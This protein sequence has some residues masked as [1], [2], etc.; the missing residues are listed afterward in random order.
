MTDKVNGYGKGTIAVQGTYQPEQGGTRVLPLYQSTTYAYETAEDTAALFNLQAAGHLYSRISNPTVASFEEK[1]ALLEGGVGAVATASGMAAI[2]NSIVNI[3]QAGDTILSSN[4][5]YGGTTNLFIANLP[6]FGIKTI[7]FD[8][9]A[10][11]EEISALADETTKLVFAET[12]SNPS[13]EVLDFEKISKVAKTLDV[14]LIIDSSLTG[15]ALINPL[16]LGAD[17]VVHSTSKYIDGHASAV[18]GIVVDGGKFNWDNGKYPELVEP[19]ESYHGVRYVADFG[20]GA[21]TTKL[22]V[23][24]VRD[25]GNIQNPFNAYLTNLGSETLDLRCQKHSSNALA[26]AEWLSQQEVVTFVK[27]PGLKTDSQY[28]LGQKYLPK[29][30]SGMVSFGVK[31]GAEAAK[32]F[33]NQLDL[34]KLVTHCAD[35]RS[36]VIHPASTTHRQLSAEQQAASGVTADLIRLSVGIEE[37]EDIIGDIAQSL[38]KLS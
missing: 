6:K 24:I 1:I 22:R 27:Y 35:I 36:S 32:S 25:L 4:Q 26:V 5:I 30:A 15:P 31:G 17:I 9:N 3:A 8:Q 10:S 29:G 33:I 38:A 18:G 7:F 2:F 16:E 13:I 23:Q 28:E 12:V 20:Q 21:Y 14:P 19:D 34:I 37:A 11:A